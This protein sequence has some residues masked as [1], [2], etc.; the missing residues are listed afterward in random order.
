MQGWCRLTVGLLWTHCRI[1]SNCVVGLKHWRPRILAT[2]EGEI[3]YKL[4]VTLLTGINL[5]TSSIFS[6]N[7]TGEKNYTCLF[8]KI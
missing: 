6:H 5:N 8:F 3:V 1:L 2:T 7:H 4:N